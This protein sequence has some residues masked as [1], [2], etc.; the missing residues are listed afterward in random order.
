MAELVDLIARTRIELGD[1]GEP[2]RA[3][4]LGD[5]ATVD[6]DLPAT[7][8]AS[9]GLNVFTM[10]GTTTKVLVEGTDFTL[11]QDNGYLLLTNPLADGLTLIC[12]GTRYG[13]FSDQ[14]LALYVQDAL[15]QHTANRTVTTRYKNSD[16]F[17]KYAE[18]PL[19]MDN[20]PFIEEKPVCVLATIEAM[21]ALANDA[22][23]DINVESP[24]GVAID[25]GQRF[26]Q[27]RAQID[28]LTDKYKMLC[29][30]LE[31][32]MYRIE[33]S[34]LRRVSRTNNRLVPIF[35]EREYD[36]YQLPERLL[37]PIDHRNE[38]ESGIPSPAWGA[39]GGW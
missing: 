13:L 1:K 10:N 25:R 14:E 37:P 12:S 24:E 32:G 3:V 22:T 33:M 6:Y 36:D 17:I 5:G 35:K 27:L 11:D 2:F 29:V 9:E 38:D 21:W 31:I 28:Y 20:L 23:T 7:N 39:Y 18:V 19:T 15:D 16:G 4:F 26:A 8:V 34:T 30:Q